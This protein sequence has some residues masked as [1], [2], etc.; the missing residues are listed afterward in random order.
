MKDELGEHLL[1]VEATSR[2]EHAGDLAKRVLPSGNVV[3]DPE[4]EH[5]VIG[6]TVGFDALG[7]PY[8]EPHP[9]PAARQAFARQRHHV[10]VEIERVQVLGAEAIQDEA[11]TNTSSAANLEG[12]P[13]SHRPAEAEKPRH[14]DV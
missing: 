13:L 10:G 14:L 11:G 12:A 2:L 6:V 8:P 9:I 4:I 1:G 3:D 7:V 5:G